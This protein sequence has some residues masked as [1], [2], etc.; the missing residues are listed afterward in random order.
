MEKAR[1]Q[2]QGSNL[3]LFNQHLS[4]LVLEIEGIKIRAERNDIAGIKEHLER[5]NAIHLEIM[6]AKM[7][8]AETCR[9]ITN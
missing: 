1:L 5:M 7:D 6:D 8:L 4:D 3:E 2:K 9:D